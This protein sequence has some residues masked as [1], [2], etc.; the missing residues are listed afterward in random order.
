MRIAELQITVSELQRSALVH[1]PHVS[2]NIST[3]SATARFGFR[4]C[5][6]T[7]PKRNGQN[8]AILENFGKILDKMQELKLKYSSKI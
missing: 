4:F 6:F 1:K 5:F 3:V 8:S 7:G 2:I